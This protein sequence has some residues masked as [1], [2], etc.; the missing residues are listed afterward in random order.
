[1]FDST[2][3]NLLTANSYSFRIHLRVYLENHIITGVQ[4]KLT[5]G[6]IVRFSINKGIK[7]KKCR[8]LPPPTPLPPP[9]P[10]P[11]PPP[12]TPHKPQIGV[13][14]CLVEGPR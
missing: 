1:M 5:I 3:A 11:P 2:I 13:F 8:W 7:K 4:Q 9:H 10:H 6:Q 14:C 12:P